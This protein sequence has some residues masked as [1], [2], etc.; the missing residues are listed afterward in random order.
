MPLAGCEVLLLLTVSPFFP[1]QERPADPSAICPLAPPTGGD[2]PPLPETFNPSAP[3]IPAGCAV[4]APALH[5]L[6]RTELT[7]TLSDLLGVDATD[8]IATFPVDDVG[9][10][11]DNNSSL[12]TV[13]PLFFEKLEEAT[14]ALVD[15]ALARPGE[16]PVLVVKEAEYALGAGVE[17][18]RGVL[19]G[20][21]TASTM[22][23]LP[24][25]AGTYAVRARVGVR[26][27]RSTVTLVVDGAEL[28][29][30]AVRADEDD[31]QIVEVRTA[32]D[33]GPVHRVDVRA[34]DQ[35]VVVDFIEVEGPF[36]VEALGP[37]SLSRQALVGCDISD[38]GADSLAC[39]RQTVRNFAARAWR[40]PVDHDEAKALDALVGDLVAAGDTPEQAL[41]TSFAALL[42]APRFVFRFEVDVGDAARLIDDVE[43]AA[44][45][46]YFVWSSTPDDRL[47]TLASEG[48]LQDPAVL[49]G[50]VR[51]MLNDPRSS[52]LVESFAGQ[53]LYT[54]ALTTAAPD[55]QRFP[56]FD[57]GVREAMKCETAL[58]VDRYLRDPTL[59]ALD[60]IDDDT[61]FVNTRLAEH[62]GLVPPASEGL[63]T[64]PEGWGLVSLHGSTRSGVLTQGALLTVNSHPTRTSPTRRGKWITENLLCEPPL[65]PPPG[66]EGMI[67]ED[68]GSAGTL[69]EQLARHASDPNC[70]GCH[71]QLDP[72]GL[73]LEHY[74]AVGRWRGSDEGFA[75]DDSGVWQG[76]TF[77]GARELGAVL[78]S[79]P[80]LPFCMSKKMLSYA[81]GRELTDEDRCLVDALTARFA[82]SNYA[83][84]DLV[85]EVALSPAFRMRARPADA[86]SPEV[87]P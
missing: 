26:D 58:T 11:F 51:R 64:L 22:V 3:A 74:D 38:D 24:H 13:S 23:I 76:Y 79:H 19:G 28:P 62:Y 47:L 59:S 15:S 71:A 68:T 48:A 53:W 40:R 77:A 44:R 9:A 80:G 63:D 36:D 30:I 42:A 29:A 83:L 55:P 39:A 35:T 10:G 4:G 18:G 56:G 16:R 50:E 54:R 78:K 73:A 41:R 46:S 6:N 49:E 8:A 67:D 32:I 81:T 45:L 66:V 31:M 34:G 69:R 60:M 1:G 84:A 33:A 72:I 75:I 5:R 25:A 17:D 21:S 43:L 12:L 7:H 65:L 61:T 86:P 20:G 87:L 70:A 27:G 37:A 57:E 82:D 52:A 14:R 2:L 85:V